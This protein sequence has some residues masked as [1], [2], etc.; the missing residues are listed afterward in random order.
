VLKT[1]RLH[2]FII[3]LFVDRD[4]NVSISLTKDIMIDRGDTSDFDGQ[5]SL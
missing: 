2:I 4:G 5:A 1:D 3:D